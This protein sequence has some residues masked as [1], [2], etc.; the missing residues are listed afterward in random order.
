LKLLVD[1]PSSDEA[2][3][4]WSQSRASV[5]S[6]LLYPEARAA[7]AATARAGRV[8]QDRLPQLREKLEL[9]WQDVV[10]IEVTPSLADRAGDLAEEHALRG[11]D[12]VHLASVL[13]IDAE[14][15]VLV[16]GDG[17]LTRAARARG[18]TTARLPAQ[19]SAG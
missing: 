6:R 1:E 16:T 7:L 15:T 10:R 11:F 19:S 3:G 8:S 9:L 5:S 4:I 14:G 18:L 17:R 13:E 12:A 2:A